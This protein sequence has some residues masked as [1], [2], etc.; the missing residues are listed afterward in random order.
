[1]S[2]RW[3]PMIGVVG[4]DG[5]Y[6]S[7][8]A[9][10]IPPEGL[11]EGEG[12]FAGGEPE[13]FGACCNADN[14]CTDGVTQFDCTS[15][16]GIYQGDGTDC[17]VVVCGGG[18]PTGGCCVGNACSILTSVECSSMHG[19]YLGDGSNCFG[20]DC[21]TVSQLG[22]CHCPTGEGSCEGSYCCTILGTDCH[23]P[24]SFS[25]GF[26]GYGPAFCCPE[27][28]DPVYGCATCIDWPEELATHCCPLSTDI[29]SYYCCDTG[30]TCC[31]GFDPSTCCNDLTEQCVHPVDPETGY[32]GSFCCPIDWIP[33]GFDPCCDPATQYCCDV[34][35][36]LL[37]CLP[38]GTP[39]S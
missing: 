37:V 10:A 18:G 22:C 15:S 4:F 1:M 11:V 16:G 21:T 39:C 27:G 38:I 36:G 20:I 35:G 6:K 5:G 2:E 23:S 3:P 7:A 29:G 31:G 25:A 30:Y 19:T 9:L 24:C 33:C 14:S 17:S 26:G 13:G 8:V 12:E 28:G 32:V 34:G